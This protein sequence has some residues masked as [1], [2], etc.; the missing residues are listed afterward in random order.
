MTI[1]IGG[2]MNNNC[3]YMDVPDGWHSCVI[4]SAAIESSLI[5]IKFNI[6]TTDY[7]KALVSGFFKYAWSMDGHHVPSDELS[8]LAKCA[9]VEKEFRDLK[10][11]LAG[12][13]GKRV[14][15][16]VW[17]RCKYGNKFPL[18]CAFSSIET[19]DEMMRRIN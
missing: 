2:K 16:K 4:Y 3:H 1:K 9:G 17:H 8:Q 7:E 12:L 13:M 18:A 11:L 10:L 15:I 6:M 14:K 19:D 5:R